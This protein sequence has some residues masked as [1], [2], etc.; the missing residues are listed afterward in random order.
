MTRGDAPTQRPWGSATWK[1]ETQ[2][3][4]SVLNASAELIAEVGERN[5]TIDQVAERAGRSRMTVFRRFGSREELITSTYRREL[6]KVFDS[7]TRSIAGTS[8]A[9]DRADL[10]IN[11]FVDSALRHP[12][13]LALLGG[14]PDALVKVT[15]G[16]PDFSAQRWLQ[17][18][19]AF[20]MADDS[21]KDPLTPEDAELV[22]SLLMRVIF[23]LLL[24]PEHDDVQLRR[25]YIRRVA[26]RIV[27]H[28][29]H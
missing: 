16:G 10:V 19:C 17:E 25:A 26:E 24:L 29:P 22:G 9:V 5:L 1:S 12:V 21:L 23:S 28:A 7:V 20:V 2:T 14:E 11:Q 13:S 18:L 27:G 6:S 15:R 8:T 3:D 4:V